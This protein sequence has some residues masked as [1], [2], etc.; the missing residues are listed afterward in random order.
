M[1]K[2]GWSSILVAT[3]VLVLGFAA[4]AQQQPKSPESD[5]LLITLLLVSLP[6]TRLFDRDCIRLDT[7]G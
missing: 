5:F 6:P 3:L 7:G 1:N 2:A 4:Q